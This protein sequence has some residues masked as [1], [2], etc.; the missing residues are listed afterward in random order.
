ML[1]FRSSRNSIFTLPLTL[2]TLLVLALLASKPSWAQCSATSTDGYTV[3]VT[4]QPTS[5]VPSATS[6][7]YGYNYNIRFDYTVTFTGSNIPS[8]LYTLQTTFTCAGDGNSSNF[9]QL[10]TTQ[11]SGTLTTSSNPYRPA[12]DCNAASVASLDC[13]H[14]SVYIQGPGINTTISCNYQGRPLPVVLTS[15]TARQQSTQVLLAWCTASEVN[16]AGFT[17]EQ[18]ADGQGWQDVAYLP[19]AVTSLAAHTYQVQ[20]DRGSGARYYRLRLTD[21]NGG[22]TYSPVA[23]VTTAVEAIATLVLTP[24]PTHGYVQAVGVSTTV[25][26]TVSNLLGQVVRSSSGP[27]LDVSS[28][29]AGIYLV[30]SGQQLGRLVVE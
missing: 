24:N 27:T 1:L 11:G 9:A 2:L 15:F 20:L 8:S 14:I 17:V 3:N 13:N 18:S 30:R 21:T 4:I 5:L 29:P 23:A 22:V 6:C 16:N 19:G 7:Q 12:A 25:P 28:L 26:L 10:P